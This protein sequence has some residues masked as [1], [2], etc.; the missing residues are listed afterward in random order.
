M[1]TS[2]STPLLSR[3]K[4]WQLVGLGISGWCTLYSVA[5]LT[6]GASSVVIGNAQG[7]CFAV[8][9]TLAGVE[10]RRCKKGISSPQDLL[11]WTSGVATEHINQALVQILRTQ[12]YRVEVCKSSELQMGFGVRG[13][14]SG[15]TIVF[16]TTRWKEPVIDLQHVQATEENRKKVSA[17]LA[18][19]VSL[20]QPDEEASQFLQARPVDLFGGDRLKDVLAAEKAEAKDA[21]ESTDT[22]KTDPSAEA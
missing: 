8:A 9:M 1:E 14:N 18:V 19:I 4:S 17:D 22:K 5:V 16:E 6:W 11:Q 10:A 20:G 3:V 12:D 13:V 2:V 21:K 7:G 15:R